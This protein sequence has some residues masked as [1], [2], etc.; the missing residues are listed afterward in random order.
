MPYR[1]FEGQNCSVARALAVVGERWSLLVMR[2]VVLG[3]RRFREIQRQTGVATN[4][5]SD[6]LDTLVE[7]GVLERRAS[8]GDPATP[9]YRATRKGLDLVPVLIALSR[10][11]D[12]YESPNGPPREFFHSQCDHEI[13]S[14]MH[15][16]HCALDV[17]SEEVRARPGPGATP[18]QRADGE[19][20]APSPAPLGAVAAAAP[21]APG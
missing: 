11:G 10:W 8:S 19:L 14:L 15:C 16:P 1:E 21:K 18:E 3:R 5:L 13:E 7:R 12:V 4:I 9:E 6:R 17:R 20:P 2:E